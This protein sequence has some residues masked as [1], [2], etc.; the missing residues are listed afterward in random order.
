MI[1]ERLRIA[2]RNFA[3]RHAVRV[4]GQKTATRCEA[5][6]LPAA[7]GVEAPRFDETEAP[8]SIAHSRQESNLQPVREVVSYREL[9]TVDWFGVR[10]KHCSRLEIYDRL[11]A[12]EQATRGWTPATAS[13]RRSRCA[14]PT[15][16]ARRWWP[17]KSS[18]PTG[19]PTPTT[20]PSS[21]ISNL[22]LRS[23]IIRCHC[24]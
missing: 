4:S 10:E 20:V 22:L 13:P 18:R 23:T 5:R 17:T 19:C 9:F 8:S 6:Q 2:A 11:R 21:S 7:A 12:I 15:S 14:S 24:G 1:R 3:G 16:P